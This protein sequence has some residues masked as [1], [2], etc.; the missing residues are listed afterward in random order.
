MGVADRVEPSLVRGLDYYTRTTFEFYRRGAG[1]GQQALGGG[2]RYDGLGEL[3][4]GEATPGGRVAPRRR[5]GG[6]PPPGVG[7]ALGLA[8]GVLALAGAG[9]AR[10]E[11]ASPIAV[12]VGADPSDTAG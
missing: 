4:G 10:P 9:A 12:V 5:R 6:T 8:R 1:G 11:E 2:G 7:F 3:L